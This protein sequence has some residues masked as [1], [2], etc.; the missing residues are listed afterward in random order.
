MTDTHHRWLA[1]LTPTPGTPVERLLELP[2]GL[3]VWEQ[4]GNKLVVAA[5]AAQLEEIE[6]R[7]MASIVWLGP[8]ED[9]T[10]PENPTGQQNT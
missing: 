10:A 1:E 4:R 9:F 7:L 6:R 8:V 3:D 2:M 5:E